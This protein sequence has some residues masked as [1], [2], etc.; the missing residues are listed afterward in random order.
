[1]QYH[2]WLIFR[3]ISVPCLFV[4]FFS[5]GNQTLGLVWQTT[6]LSRNLSPSSLGNPGIAEQLQVLLTC[7]P[8]CLYMFAHRHSV[9]SFWP[10]F[11]DGAGFPT[12]HMDLFLFF[13]RVLIMVWENVSEVCR[14]STFL[15]KMVWTHSAV[16]PADTE[17]FLSCLFPWH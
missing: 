10:D 5:A 7:T 11:F 15:H 12:L 2:Y 14:F 3:K 13:L 6:Y 8:M 9:C 4:S 17:W 1:M 16:L